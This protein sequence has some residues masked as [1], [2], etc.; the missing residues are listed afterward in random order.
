M[1]FADLSYEQQVQHFTAAAQSLLPQYGLTGAHLEL[2]SYAN[3]AV[4]KVS[5]SP[6]E[7]YVLRIHRPGHKQIEWIRSEL[8]WLKALNDASVAQVPRPMPT[9][10]GD[11]LVEVQIESLADRLPCVLFQWIEGQFYTADAIALDKVSQAA[12]FLAHLHQF[13]LMF[14]PPPNFTRPL[15]D[16]EGLFGERSPYNPGEGVRIFTA[17]QKIVF[18]E[19]EERVQAVFTELDK[20]PPSIGII[21]ADFLPKNFLFTDSGVAAIDFDDSSWGYYLY[22]L[23]PSL[24][25]FKSEKRYEAL[26]EAWIGGYTSVRE[27]PP[28]SADSLEAFMAAR[29][30]AS[31]RWQAGHLHNPRIREHAAEV[32]AKRTEDLR[33]FLQTGAL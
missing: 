11:W 12:A 20:H 2:L 33:R 19:V 13:A 27:L 3:N 15:L 23:S 5:L 16:W 24:L 10:Q 26:R 28:H 32:I 21:H 9:K 22:D 4:F 14:E 7:N 29:H 18:A 17:D 8:M 1:T 6:N 25:L 30:L 31:C